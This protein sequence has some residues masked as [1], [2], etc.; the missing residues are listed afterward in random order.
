MIKRVEAPWTDDQVASLNAYQKAGPFHPFTYGEGNEQ[1]DLIATAA[2]WVAHHG[3]PVVQKWA[4]EFM[5]DW[6]WRQS[7]RRY[8]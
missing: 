1:V 6:S 2:G 3:G 4:H 8:V 7:A 5:A